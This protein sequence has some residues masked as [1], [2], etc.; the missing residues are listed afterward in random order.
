MFHDLS[1]ALREFLNAFTSPST[2]PSY[3]ASAC[4]HSGPIPLTRAWRS[5]WVGLEKC[6]GWMF[7]IPLFQGEHWRMGGWRDRCPL[8]TLD[9]SWAESQALGQAL[10]AASDTGPMPRA[11]SG[12]KLAQKEHSCR[13][14]TELNRLGKSK[15]RLPSRL[16]PQPRAS[17]CHWQP[18]VEQILGFLLPGVLMGVRLTPVSVQCTKTQHENT[19]R[20]SLAYTQLGRTLHQQD[21]QVSLS[22]LWTALWEWELMLFNFYKI[23]ELPC[24]RI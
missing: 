19:R 10:D 2:L 13:Q 11:L 21:S 22:R 3:T 16:S 9:N 15:N 4:N 20:K 5:F 7:L 23:L 18:R 24:P 1:K 8:Q 17:S 12:L 6:Q 14:A